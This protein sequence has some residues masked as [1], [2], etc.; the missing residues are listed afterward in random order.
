[1]TV[2]QT[3]QTPLANG[4]DARQLD[5]ILVLRPWRDES[6]LKVFFVAVR[7]LRSQLGSL[8]ALRWVL[9]DR[10]VLNMYDDYPADTIK[11]D[12]AV[13]MGPCPEPERSFTFYPSVYD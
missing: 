10:E 4:E 11:I 7:C 3:Y 8:D 1:L 2:A 12:D 9:V 13:L 5:M 6:T